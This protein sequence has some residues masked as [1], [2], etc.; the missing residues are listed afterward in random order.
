MISDR[1]LLLRASADS[2]V[3]GSE[4][5][6]QVITGASSGATAV[7]ETSVDFQQ[8]GVGISELQVANVSG[9]FTDGEK[10]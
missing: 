10:K 1:K 9:T 3:F 2:G 6:G 5:I 7:V 8:A 4:I